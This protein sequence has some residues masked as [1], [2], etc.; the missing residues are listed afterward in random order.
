MLL[1]LHPGVLIEF[2]LVSGIFQDASGP[3]RE[4]IM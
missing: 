2:S 3:E 4:M 1:K